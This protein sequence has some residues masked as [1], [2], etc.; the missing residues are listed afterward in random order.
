MPKPDSERL[1]IAVQSRYSPTQEA[2]LKAAM[3]AANIGTPS[4]FQRK[5]ALDWADRVLGGA[6]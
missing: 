2:R 4:E 3:A 5:A 6:K 1:T